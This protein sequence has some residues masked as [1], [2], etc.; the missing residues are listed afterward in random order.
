MR[1]GNYS[2]NASE[3]VVSLAH[4]LKYLSSPEV[5]NSAYGT[6]PVKKKAM[7]S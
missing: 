2:A 3:T 5:L 4:R 7:Y 6:Q 1:V